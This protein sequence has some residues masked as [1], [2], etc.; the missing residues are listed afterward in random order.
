MVFLSAIRDVGWLE[1]SRLEWMPVQL[2]HNILYR[3]VD[4]LAIVSIVRLLM[5]SYYVLAS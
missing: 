2:A 5:V 4:K 3:K 1:Y